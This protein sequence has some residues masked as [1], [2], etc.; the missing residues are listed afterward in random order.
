MD[1]RVLIGCPVRNRAWI[2]PRYLQCLQKLDYPPDLLEYCFIVNGCE[3]NTPAVLEDFAAVC[4]GTARIIYADVPA[5]HGHRRGQYNLQYLAY[6]RN[7][8]LSAFLQTKCQ[9]LFSLDSDILA[10]RQ[11]LKQLIADDCDIISALVCN[12]HLLKEQNLFN[13]LRKENG[14]YVHMRNVPR[15]RVFTVDCT[16]AAYLIKRRVIEKYGVRY[17]AQNGAE[18]IG[19]CEMAQSM[20]ITICCDGRIECEHIMHEPETDRHRFYE[21]HTDY[22][23]HMQDKIVWHPQK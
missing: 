20:G 8:L 13:V 17:S 6:L 10:P 22:K 11:A 4:N 14:N 3:D 16:G 18:D 2:L 9:Y 1:Y 23:S 15:D 19:F 12:G 21:M 5:S 7:L